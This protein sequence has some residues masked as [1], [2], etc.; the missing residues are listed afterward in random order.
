MIPGLQNTTNQPGMNTPQRGQLAYPLD[1]ESEG[2][3]RA[4]LENVEKDVIRKRN[5]FSLHLDTTKTE[6][7]VGSDYMVLTADSTTNIARIGGGREGQI[8]LLE[9]GD[10]DLRL[11][12]NDSGD[13]NTINLAG[14]ATNFTSSSNGMMQIHFN[15]TSWREVSRS[16]N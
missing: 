11:T 6:F 5:K 16:V 15:G 2:A 12:D 13:A 4:A 14:T 9:F 3:L 8:L 7:N 10:S 1:L